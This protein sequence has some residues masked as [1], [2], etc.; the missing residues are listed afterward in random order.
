MSS[1]LECTLPETCRQTGGWRRKCDRSRRCDKSS[2]SLRQAPPRTGAT[3]SRERALGMP[4]T[5]SLGPSHIHQ[6]RRLRASFTRTTVRSPSAHPSHP[7]TDCRSVRTL[8]GGPI[9]LRSSGAICRSLLIQVNSRLLG[10]IKSIL[11]DLYQNTNPAVK[12][13]PKIANAVASPHNQ[14]LASVSDAVST[15]FSP[16]SVMLSPPTVHSRIWC[17]FHI[18]MPMN[19]NATISKNAIMPKTHFTVTSAT[20][21]LM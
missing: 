1:R 6:E 19:P 3:A 11:K 10:C 17:P 7:I 4:P 9:V 12:E 18:K 5:K 8:E 15:T 16:S 21:S 13:S 2:R 14:T 20:H